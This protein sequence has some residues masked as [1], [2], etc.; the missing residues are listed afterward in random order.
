[1]FRHQDSEAG[2]ADPY[3][4]E[5]PSRMQSRSRRHRPI[6]VPLLLPAS[7]TFP[8]FRSNHF[9][10]K[11]SAAHRNNSDAP[12]A[13]INIL[14]PKR[15]FVKENSR[16]QVRSASDQPAVDAR[17][18]RQQQIDQNTPRK[19]EGGEY[20]DAHGR[21][22]RREQ[23]EI[24]HDLLHQ[25]MRQIVSMIASSQGSQIG[26]LVVRNAIAFDRLADRLF[27]RPRR[28]AALQQI[29]QCRAILLSKR[30]REIPRDHHL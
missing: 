1:M 20:R 26:L 6:A 30:R 3:H 16:K 15:R 29:R 27:M 12:K 25:Q 28:Q 17:N 7:M 11:A 18:A 2:T 5:R 13:S 4:Q 8:P 22:H 10:L 14:C 19:A 21:S 9:F 23:A 24:D